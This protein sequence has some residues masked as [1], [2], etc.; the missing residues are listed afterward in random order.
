MAL[1]THIITNIILKGAF[2]VKRVIM[3]KGVLEILGGEEEQ[4]SGD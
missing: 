4:V 3:K 1:P 2:R